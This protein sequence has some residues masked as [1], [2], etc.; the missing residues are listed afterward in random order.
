MSEDCLGSLGCIMLY[1]MTIQSIATYCNA[2]QLLFNALVY[3]GH[4]GNPGYSGSA[5]GSRIEEA[6]SNRAGLQHDDWRQAST[7]FV[8]W[9]CY[10][11]PFEGYFFP[12]CPTY[13][14]MASAIKGLPSCSFRVSTTNLQLCSGVRVTVLTSPLMVAVRWGNQQLDASC[15]GEGMAHGRH[16]HCVFRR[17]MMIALLESLVTWPGCPETQSYLYLDQSKVQKDTK[18]TKKCFWC[19]SQF[20]T[21]E[22]PFS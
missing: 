21:E 5:C 17:W 10:F 14:I 2:L 1:P 22:R 4:R 20:Y 18:S 3:I 7:W 19:P 6:S 16:K 11:Q 12:S 15:F 13:I 9:F 8:L